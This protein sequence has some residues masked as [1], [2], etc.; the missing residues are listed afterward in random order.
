M[1]LLRTERSVKRT[2]FFECGGCQ[3]WWTSLRLTVDATAALLKAPRPHDLV[4][5][6]VFFFS[7][8]C[9]GLLPR[10][11]FNTPKVIDS[12]RIVAYL[13]NSTPPL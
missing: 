6:R 10:P 12:T 8:Y 4:L 3:V 7:F 2:T 1:V 5:N 13:Q 11:W 9:V